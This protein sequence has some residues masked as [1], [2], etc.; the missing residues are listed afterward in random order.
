MAGRLLDRP[1]G[2]Y[3]LREVIGVGAFGEVYRAV[4]LG[5]MGFRK[6]VAL[7]LILPEVASDP[8]RLQG[9]IDEARVCGLLR[10]PNLVE[11]YEFDQVDGTWYL[12]MEHVEGWS[13]ADVLLRARVEGRPATPRA[14]V[15][16]G[17]QAAA[18]LA[19]AHEAV[20][21][22]G[23]PLKL[24]HR[25]LK[26]G[27]LLVSRR[28][29]VKIGDFGIAQAASNLFRTTTDGHAKG[30]PGFMSPEQVRGEP[31]DGRSDLF[32]LGAVLYEAA[33]TEPL[34]PPGGEVYPLLLRVERA[35]V[36][37]A[38]R[39]LRARAPALA[40][41]LGR[42][43]TRTPSERVPSARR[44]GAELRALLDGLGPG[45]GLADWL[46]D[47]Y[48]GQVQRDDEPDRPHGR[49]SGLGPAW[50]GAPPRDQGSSRV[51]GGPAPG[52]PSTGVPVR[53]DEGPRPGVHGSAGAPISIGGDEARDTLTRR[54]P[55]RGSRR[56]SAAR[57]AAILSITCALL[58][59]GW[60][61]TRGSGS[62]EDRSGASPELTAPRPRADAVF[63][64][65]SLPSRVPG[66]PDRY[67]L[68]LRGVPLLP[69]GSGAEGRRRA[70]HVAPALSYALRQR[71]EAGVR[72][73]HA[74]GR[75]YLA[76]ESGE[77]PPTP[78]VTASPGHDADLDWH[79]MVVLDG[80]RALALGLPP[81]HTAGTAAGELLAG[82]AGGDDPFRMDPR[83]AER[84][85][86]ARPQDG[87]R[88]AE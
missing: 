88:A 65:L 27:N 66:G 21:D 76:A 23:R 47:L 31:L 48:P 44:L 75:G 9:F 83:A 74:P 26:P 20:D 19:F 1:F 2:P 8:A 62:A 43:L 61:W 77:R 11:V 17:I 3:V 59:I 69:M 73:H 86:L 22:A 53:T 28:G 50:S 57:T 18:G 81:R 82:I 16:L 37:P 41:L 56:S 64:P 38:L 72:V 68:A 55:V 70:E 35:E 78:L 79:R 51:P 80:W 46:E 6:D 87:R 39:R 40:D 54:A 14:A 4:L 7:K 5:P 42:V 67:A 32:P 29:E 24:V 71:G 84:V 15:E 30:T 63:A 60:F 34:F 49:S 25:D 58:A 12:A 45:P 33:T 13:L 85:L 10:H 52:P 36:S